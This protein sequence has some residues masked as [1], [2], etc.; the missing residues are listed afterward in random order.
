MLPFSCV[1]QVKLREVR[2]F[3]VANTRGNSFVVGGRGRQSNS[4]EYYPCPSTRKGH[5]CEYRVSLLTMRKLLFRVIYFCLL[6]IY[7]TVPPDMTGIIRT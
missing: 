3:V 4:V 7:A 2:E 6:R 5:A 1:A